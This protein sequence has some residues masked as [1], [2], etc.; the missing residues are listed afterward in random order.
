MKYQNWTDLEVSEIDKTINCEQM[1]RIALKK[2]EKL[3]RPIVQVCGP[4]T[5]G[6]KGSIEANIKEFDIAI[7]RLANEGKIVFDQRP[8]EIPMQRIRES[9]KDVIYAHELL[10]DFYLPIF[11]SGLI[12]ELYFLEGWEKSTGAKWE[13]NKAQELKIKISYFS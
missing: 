8:F 13:H 6:G 9:M 11:E 10:N 5:T 2:L 7:N 1:L 4:I 12:D 3:P